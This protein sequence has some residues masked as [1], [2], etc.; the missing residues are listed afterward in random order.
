MTHTLKSTDKDFRAAIII[1][2]PKNFKEM[3]TVMRKQMG[4]LSR[5]MKT[6]RIKWIFQN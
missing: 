4:D 1:T 6:L 3:M 5:E 2:M